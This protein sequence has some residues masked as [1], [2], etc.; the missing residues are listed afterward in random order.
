MFLSLVLGNY[1]GIWEVSLVGVSLGTLVGLMI[2]IVEIS[3]VGISL[4]LPLGYPLKSPNPGAEL[5]G[6]LL[7][8][9]W[10]VV[11][12]WSGKVWV[13]LPPPRGFPQ[14]NLLG[15]RYFLHTSLWIYYHV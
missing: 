7:G 12:I 3:L 13:V 2:R 8:T 10:F 11:L 9:F 5:P 6:T 4:V 1:F 14:S 15:G